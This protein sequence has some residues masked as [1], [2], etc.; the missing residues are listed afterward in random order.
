MKSKVFFWK[1]SLQ[2]KKRLICRPYHAPRQNDEYQFFEIRKSVDLNSSIYYKWNA[3]ESQLLQVEC[4]W[5]TILLTQFVND[6]YAKNVVSKKSCF[7][8][9]TTQSVLIL[10]LLTYRRVF[11]IQKLWQDCSDWQRFSFQKRKPRGVTYR[12]YEN[13]SD[14]K[15]KKK[16]K[17]ALR[18]N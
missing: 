12:N 2:K 7:K 14:T 11:K 16:S 1:I 9:K 17:S 5:I 13:F 4:L 18:F 8:V 15:T 3:G 6:H 10:F